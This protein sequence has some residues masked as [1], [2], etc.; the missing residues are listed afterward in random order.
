[1]NRIDKIV[2]YKPLGFEQ[3]KKIA[4]LQIADLQE[5][6]AKQKLDLKVTPALVKFIAE[7][8]YDPAQ[9]A[10]FIRKNIQSLLEDSLAEKIISK[11]MENGAVVTADVKKDNVVFDT[12]IK[13][14]KATMTA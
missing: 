5:R 3:L 10:R 13:K 6:L 2:V 4:V 8:S 1:L 7:K 9:G 11:N 14:E 12:Q